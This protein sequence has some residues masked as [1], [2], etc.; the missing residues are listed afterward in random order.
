M[1]IMVC[2]DADQL[3][4][5]VKPCLEFEGFEVVVV[6]DDDLLSLVDRHKP[7]LVIVDLIVRGPAG[8]NLARQLH[9]A[10]VRVL[11]VHGK[12]PTVQERT[13]MHRLDIETLPKTIRFDDLVY[14]VQLCL[15]KH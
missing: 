14:R 9:G 1:K 5:L 15:T 7:D 10:N 8:Q 13:L 11:A 3:A 4:Q 2:N 6:S 12:P